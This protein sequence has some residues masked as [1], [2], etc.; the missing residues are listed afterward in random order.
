MRKEDKEETLHVLQILKEHPWAWRV[1]EKEDAH[2][3]PYWWHS[4]LTNDS[5][6]SEWSFVAPRSPGVM[7]ES[8]AKRMGAQRSGINNPGCKNKIV[9]YEEDT[10]KEKAKILY[11]SGLKIGK[12]KKVLNQ[13]FPNY[14]Y[15]FADIKTYDFGRGHNKKNYLL[16]HLLGKD[17]SNFIN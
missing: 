17:V 8:S 13:E 7:R 1:N 9:Y 16:A 14:S 2:R 6:L 5:S 10:I 11:Y 3:D 4:V 12:I 15:M